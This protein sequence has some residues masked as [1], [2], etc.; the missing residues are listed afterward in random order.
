MHS[1]PALLG[2]EVLSPRPGTYA[3]GPPEDNSE[4]DANE[5]NRILRRAPNQCVDHCDV[6]RERDDG[7]QREFSFAVLEM[8]A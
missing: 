5:Q 6:D 7:L 2:L 8:Q 1:I 3:S 4:I